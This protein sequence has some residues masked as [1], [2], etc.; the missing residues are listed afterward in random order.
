M[1]RDPL[2]SIVIPVYNGANYL[3]EAIDSALAQTYP[4]IEV[5]VVNDGS[6]DNGATEAIAKSYGDKIRYFAKENG[7]VSS[8]LN[9]GI[10]QMRG[11]YFS[12]LSHDDIYTST[13]VESHIAKINDDN[14]D[15]I[16]Y[17]GSA[18]IDAESK[19]LNRRTKNLPSGFYPYDKMLSAIFR[20]YMPGGC[21]LLIPKKHFEAFGTFDAQLRYMQ[22]ADMWYRFLVG[23]VNFVCHGE[24]LGVL[25]RVHGQQVTVTSKHLY[26]KDL[27]AAGPVLVDRLAALPE[28]DRYLL[29]AYMLLSCREDSALAAKKAYELLRKEARLSVND[30]CK[31][32]MVKLY[33]KVRPFLVKCYYRLFFHIKVSR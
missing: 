19:P 4:N 15:C 9:L 30:R 17:C 32:R 20:G 27:N 25:S 6:S 33:G 18:F 22:D 23:G 12:W 24:D 2:V 16:F 7:G 3:K 29:K 28:K 5:L 11:E 1:N 10:Q 8:A 14:A 21:A 31:Y 26:K 13:K